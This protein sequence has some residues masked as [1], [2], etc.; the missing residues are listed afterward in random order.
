MAAELVGGMPGRRGAPA[1]RPTL[2]CARC[3][4]VTIP[5][6]LGPLSPAFMAQAPVEG[7]RT[8]RCQ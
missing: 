4:H 2:P 7:R 6:G 1:L 5:A 8:Q 3:G